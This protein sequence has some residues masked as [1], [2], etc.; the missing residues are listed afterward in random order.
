MPAESTVR[1]WALDD[2]SG[3]YARYIRARNLGLDAKADE[4]V[5]IADKPVRS[6]KRKD[7]TCEKCGGLGRAEECELCGGTGKHPER[8]DTWRCG[9]C[10]CRSCGG[11]GMIS[12]VTTGDS[13]ERSKLR[14]DTRKWYLS[15]LA[16]KRYG[17][18]I[19]ID[20]DDQPNDSLEE[21]R[22]QAMQYYR[23]KSKQ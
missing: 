22:A 13:V 1:A 21:L 23:E 18:R 6:T 9:K 16:P 19:Q 2:V 14:V 15:K 4:T 17:D 11:T 12:E 3:F 20:T 10:K 7:K 5:E 8:P